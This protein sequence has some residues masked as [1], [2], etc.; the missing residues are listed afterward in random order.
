[1]GD[2]NSG[3]LA[4]IAVLVVVVFII[5]GYFNLRKH[6]RGIEAPRDAEVPRGEAARPVSP[7]SPDEDAGS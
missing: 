2:L 5:I 1:M 4:L 3:L 6:V 7:K